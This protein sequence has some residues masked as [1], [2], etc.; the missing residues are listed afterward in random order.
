M[1]KASKKDSALF[2]D[3]GP[4]V[5]AILG[6]PLDLTNLETLAK[7]DALPIIYTDK[8]VERPTRPT[9]RSLAK[10]R[11]TL[12]NAYLSSPDSGEIVDSD[13]ED[14]RS[15]PAASRKRVRFDL[16]GDDT[17]AKIAAPSF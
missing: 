13:N 11:A 15:D 17:V 12:E 3:L 10:K 8:I 2:K 14:E 9:T 6:E 16:P 4:E 7:T 1:Y 5:H